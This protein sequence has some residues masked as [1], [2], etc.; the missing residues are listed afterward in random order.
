MPVPIVAARRSPFAAADG[1]LAGWHP[2]DLA[3]TVL[4]TTLDQA[5]IAGDA[6]DHLFVG[7]DEPVGAQ[8][9]NVARAIILGAGWP[10]TVGGTTV[11]AAPH[12]GMSALVAAC[13]AIA[14]GRI[15]SA[16]VVGLSLAS[17]VTPGASALARVYGRPWGDGPAGRYTDVGGLVPPIVAA[18][19]VAGGLGFDR[20]AQES[21]GLRSIGR[22]SSPPSA[23]V[24][25][26]ARP[27]SGVAVQR[28]TPV[29][30]DVI[31]AITVDALEP[32]F[33]TDG[34]TT[35]AGFAPPADGV[36]V[37]VLGTDASAMA[38]IDP[39][40][41]AAGSPFDLRGPVIAAVDDNVIPDRVD[42]AAGSASMALVAVDALAVDAE[43]VDA[44][45]GTIAVGDAAAAEDLRL[46]IDGIHH[47]APGST[48]R[49]LRVA[50]G[51]AAGCVWRRL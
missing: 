19:R 25:V 8:G 23:F 18:D 48:G 2:V 5:G 37:I 44:S 20:A 27:G 47:A 46:V 38:E 16:V 1:V 33:D 22:R 13:D 36:S 3:V 40:I 50:P 14:A 15:E 49:A 28:D 21:W 42:L 24:T 39:T 31:R 4:D 45:G 30:A 51:A 35:A 34:T 17:I 9:A 7:C 32:I 12:S 6:I 10:E 11:D 43:L 29:S 26:G 41:V